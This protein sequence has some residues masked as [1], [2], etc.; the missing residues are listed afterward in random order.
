MKKFYLCLA[1]LLGLE[2]QGFAQNEVPAEKGRWPDCRELS[3]R[4]LTISGITAGITPWEMTDPSNGVDDW[5]IDFKDRSGEAVGRLYYYASVTDARGAAL[6]ELAIRA[7]VANL[8][9]TINGCDMVRDK[10]TVGFY[11]LSISAIKP[12]P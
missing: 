12:S 1:I 9:V 4:P 10:P 11:S 5:S 8:E 2:G 6:F 7:M 3:G